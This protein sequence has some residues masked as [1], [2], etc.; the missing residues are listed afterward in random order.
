MLRSRVRSVVKC[1]LIGGAVGG[2]ALSLHT[3]QYQVDSIGIV[4]LARAACTVFQIGVIYKKDLYMKGLDKKSIEY[5]ELK[6]QCHKRSAEKLL[7]LCCTNK[8]VYIKVGQH[9][10]ALEYLLPSEYV[11]TLK[12]LHSNAPT[13]KLDDIYKVLKEDLKQEP[14]QLFDSF[15]PKP[16]GT[17]SLAQVHRATLRDGTQVAVKVQHPYVQGNSKVDMKTM[18]YLVKIMSWVFPEFKFQWLVDE[19]KKNIPQE[20]NFMQ[21]GKNAEK[22]SEMFKDVEWLRVPKVIWNLSTSRV[23]TMEFVDGGQVNDLD[24]I[25]KHGIDPKE[26]SDKLGQ[27]YSR[28]IFINGFVHSDPHPGNILVKKNQKGHCDIILLDH[29]LY[30]TL[31]DEFRVEYANLWLA[32]LN[33]DRVAMR[34]HCKNLG[35]EGNA[36]GLFACMVTGRTWD[37]IMRG[38]DK[39]G[40]TK[41][42]KKLMKQSFTSI[43][44]QISEVLQNVNPQMLLILKTNDLMRGIE[45]TLKTGARMGA[46]REMSQCCI[47]SVYNLQYCRTENRLEKLKIYFAEFWALLKI[48]L[49]Y[50]LLN[51]KNF[52]S[53]YS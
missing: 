38:I 9:I 16:L 29:G 48:N 36:Y 2:T 35:I 49:Y 8:G 25:Q 14:S 52:C 6:S 47:K 17:A 42:E 12:I 20:L 7:E 34:Y 46:F 21:E 19:S 50:T 45:H 28:M 11:D 18:E 40:M 10:A 31:K 3:N 23:L 15:D 5:K 24:Y 53:L 39:G 27:L 43:L 33:K 1:F 13:N 32:I 51:I 44:P 30:A 22:V 26:V 41:S 37:S 4:R